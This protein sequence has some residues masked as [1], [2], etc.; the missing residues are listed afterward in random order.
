MERETA[1]VAVMSPVRGNPPEL[2]VIH[3][4]AA[5]DLLQEAGRALLVAG[6]Y[7]LAGQLGL[8]ASA[9]HSVVSSLWPPAGLGVF[10]LI[11]YGWRCWPGIALG[12]F[13]LN[14]TAGV[15]LAG[16]AGIAI[17]NTLEA[18]TAAVLLGRLKFSPALARVRDVLS[19]AAVATACTLVAAIIGTTSLV[20]TG[21]SPVSGMLPLILVWWSGDAVGVFVVAPLLLAWTE[22]RRRVRVFRGAGLLVALETIALFG[23]LVFAAERLLSRTSGYYPIF[24]IVMLI[25]LRRGIRGAA[26]AVAAVAVI[27]SWK[28]LSGDGPFFVSVEGLYQLQ[29]FLFLLSLSSLLFASVFTERGQSAQQAR[30]SAKQLVNAQQ[31]ARMG[32]WHWDIARDRVSWSPELYHIFGVEPGSFAGTVHAFLDH[33]HAEDQQWVR[34]TLERAIANRQGFRLHERIVRPDG[35]VRVLATA[36]EVVTDDSGTPTQLLGVCQDVTEQWDAERSL[37][38]REA[39]L[40]AVFDRSAVGIAMADPDGRYVRANRAFLTMLGYAEAE[41]EH[42]TQSMITRVKDAASWRDLVGQ[43]VRGRTDRGQIEAQLRRKDGGLIWTRNTLSLIQDAAGRP[44]YVIAVVEEIT[45]QKRA[46]LELQQVQHAYRDIVERAPIPIFRSTVDGRILLANRAFADMLGYRTPEALRTLDLRRDVYRRP[47]DRDALV[48][49]YERMHQPYSVE[50]EWKRADGAP[51]W[52]LL[53]V[54][55]VRDERGRMRHFENFVQDITDRK[56][57]DER[58]DRINRVS[59]VLASTLDVDRLLEL[60]VVQGLALVGAD[61]GSGCAGL[62]QGG[63]LVVRRYYRA[64]RW[65][66]LERTLRLGECV[67]GWVAEQ[68]SPYLTNQTD[69]DP[70]IDR[71]L[72]RRFGI[73]NLLATPIIGA[74]G[75]PLGYFEL[76]NKSGSAGFTTED[77][78]IAQALAHAAALAIQNALS[79]REVQRSAQRYRTLALHLPNATVAVLD[80]DLRVLL[81][82]DPFLGAAEQEPGRE[83]GS[84]GRAMEGRTLSEVLPAETAAE[85]GRQVARVFEDAKVEFELEVAERAHLVRLLPL[86]DEQGAVSACMALSVDITERRRQE[87][88]RRL[89]LARLINAQEDERRRIARELHDEAGQSLTALRMGLDV[90]RVS[91]SF[92]DVRA[93][94]ARLASVASDAVKNLGRLARGLH[95]SVL[96]DLGLPAALD[97]YARDYSA[98]YAIPVDLQ[99]EGFDGRRF[100][101]QVETTV[102]R[103]VLEALTNIARH[104]KASRASIVLRRE[105]GC[106]EALVEDDGEGFDVAAVLQDPAAPRAFGLHGIRERAELMSGT[107]TIESASG[108]GTTIAVRIPVAD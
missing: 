42:L 48:S 53:T 35:T 104:S 12:A 49:R 103:I 17:G 80:R 91:Q 67:G 19:L 74:G 75:E 1:A 76:H 47:E 38:E 81:A 16:A 36:G 64:G 96:D 7:Y 56:R 66:P 79:Y 82:E 89:L 32:S 93:H 52:V 5:R 45:E 10:I 2:P 44:K 71:V 30:Q 18:L 54:R 51:V 29:Q 97:R 27:A 11:R 41:L 85:L 95:P 92:D 100:Q 55:A 13:A 4:S 59:G 25:S 101:P 68:K 34:E 70:Q 105:N 78:E 9:A 8:L 65:V 99:I 94:A 90:I 14:A 102:Y 98:T 83:Q 46:E 86:Y 6:S 60:I 33:V 72:T 31:I 63:Q 57:A 69:T 107:A 62:M 3:A 39:L 37:R 20:V 87:Q 106:I 43:L 77:R 28:A 40:G 88:L 108:R 21:S 22:R 58:L 23:L 61:P 15:P 26:S 73:Y 50:L 24:P 84:G